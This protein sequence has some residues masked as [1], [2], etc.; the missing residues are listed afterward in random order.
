M[1]ID[2]LYW[3]FS[4][5]FVTTFK[6]S[7]KRLQDEICSPTFQRFIVLITLVQVY[8]SGILSSEQRSKRRSKPNT[9]KIVHLIINNSQFIWVKNGFHIGIHYLHQAII[10][11]LHDAS[12]RAKLESNDYPPLQHSKVKSLDICIHSML[13]TWL[14]HIVIYIVIIHNKLILKCFMMPLLLLCLIWSSGN[15]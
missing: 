3:Y 10:I 7:F 13:R 4:I 5:L 1:W 6:C 11:G 8:S 15:I 2:Y 12:W 14:V 9:N